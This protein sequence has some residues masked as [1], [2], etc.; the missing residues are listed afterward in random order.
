MRTD[1]P[2]ADHGVLGGRVGRLQRGADARRQRGDVDDRAVVPG[3]EE[4]Q[5]LL[6]PEDVAEHV[7]LEEPADLL[8]RHVLQPADGRDG[9]DVQ[10]RVDVPEAGDR[11]SGRARRPG[12]RRSRPSA[13]PAPGRPAPR[14]PVPP[15]PARMPTVRRGQPSR[16]ASPAGGPSCRPIPLDAPVTTTTCVPQPP[17]HH[18]V[19]PCGAS[20]CTWIPAEGRPTPRSRPGRRCRPADRGRHRGAGG[21]LGR[22]CRARSTSRRGPRRCEGRRGRR[23]PRRTSRRS[24]PEGRR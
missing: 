12:P 13:R 14:T 5:R 1:S 7:D 24:G 23:R 20:L 15:R 3:P 22:R 2:E 16:P 6:H 9:G 8:R 18:R 21:P 19:L 10:P 17:R 11:P 4:A